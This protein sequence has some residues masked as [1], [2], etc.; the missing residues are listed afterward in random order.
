MRLGKCIAY[1]RACVYSRLKFF[2]APLRSTRVREPCKTAVA[3]QTARKP[4][5][6]QATVPGGE[7][8][9]WLVVGPGAEVRGPDYMSREVPPQELRPGPQP[10]DGNRGTVAVRPM[11]WTLTEAGLPHRE[12]RTVLFQSPYCVRDGFNQ[13]DKRRRG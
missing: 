9:Y 13:A 8:C 5:A 10:Q 4:D 7:Y 11:D 6:V 1:I 12:R 2:V 3:R